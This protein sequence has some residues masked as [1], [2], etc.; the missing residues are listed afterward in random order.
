MSYLPY[1]LALR[2]I[3]ALVIVSQSP[4]SAS[5]RL[6]VIKGNFGWPVYTKATPRSFHTDRVPPRRRDI[7]SIGSLCVITDGLPPTR[8]WSV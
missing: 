2:V 3:L 5:L 1:A 6:Y 4:I 8:S 7:C